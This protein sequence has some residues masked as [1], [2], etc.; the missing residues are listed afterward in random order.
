MINKL[1]TIL[2]ATYNGE[3][4][5]EAQIESLLKQ[6]YTNWH[7]I[8]RDD[9]STDKT[10]AILKQYQ[11]QHP[12]KITILP[13]AGANVGSILNFNAL[14]TF[15]QDAQ[16]IMF[17]D[18]D[19]RWKENKIA[20][21]FSKLCELEQQYGK[22]C[23]LLVYTNFQYVDE[24]LQIIESK[25]NFEVNRIKH[26]GF[27]HLLAQNPVYGCTTIINRALADKI[28][29]IPASAENHDYWIALVAAAFGKLYYLNEKTIFYRQHARNVSGNFDNN[30]FRKRFQRIILNK[31][32]FKDAG[33]KYAMLTTFKEM[34]GNT[35][36]KK[37][38]TVLNNFLCFFSNKN[39][40]CMIKSIKNG[41]RCQTIM[42]SG[43]LYTTIFL[44][45]FSDIKVAIKGNTEAI[46]PL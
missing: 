15:A 38:A 36:D 29:F 28:G 9:N 46:K 33:N 35:L 13:S 42:Q 6:T 45:K 27:S 14:L 18:Q 8:I 22:A 23:P 10:L 5:L 20:T 34:Y 21:T 25:K 11:Q 31:R 41:V 32:N 16:Y 26:F 40:A 30:T 7:L 3:K 2:L 37:P 12:E 44:K 43:L 39:L 17:C 4:Y 19:D 1:I 24:T